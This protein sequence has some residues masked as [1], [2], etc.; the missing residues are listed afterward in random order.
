MCY[1]ILKDTAENSSIHFIAGNRQYKE[2]MSG[3]RGL[4]RFSPHPKMEMVK[5]LVLDHL[6]TKGATGEGGGIAEF[7]PNTRVMVFTSY[8]KC[9]EEVVDYL[10]LASPAIKATKFVGQRKDKSGRKGCAQ[11]DQLDVRASAIFLFGVTHGLSGDQKVQGRRI[12]HFGIDLY[13][14]RGSGH[15]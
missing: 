12:Q 11:K 7:N 10:N 9:V 4:D 14:R 2:L 13:R 15:R 1:D 3:F 8:R 6:S 5:S